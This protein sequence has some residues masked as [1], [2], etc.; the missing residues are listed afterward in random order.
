MLYCYTDKIEIG[1]QKLKFNAPKVRFL[2][3]KK[4]IESPSMSL[5]KM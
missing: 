5:S 1:Y 3:Q 2:V 4:L